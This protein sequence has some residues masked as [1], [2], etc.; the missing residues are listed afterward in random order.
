MP[1]IAGTVMDARMPMMSIT[2]INSMR[3]KPLCGPLSVLALG[4]TCIALGSQLIN[5]LRLLP[6]HNIVLVDALVGRGEGIGQT[7]GAQR[8]HHHYPS[9]FKCIQRVLLLEQAIEAFQP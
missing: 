4:L 5:G 8:P 3:V 2:T 1:F 7:V 6:A 9:I